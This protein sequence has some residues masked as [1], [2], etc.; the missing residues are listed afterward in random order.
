ML[1]AE[2]SYHLPGRLA[3]DGG[4]AR[5]DVRREREGDGFALL[6]IA[7]VEAVVHHVVVMNAVELD[8]VPDVHAVLVDQA[9][10]VRLFLSAD[11]VAEL[12]GERERAVRRRRIG[13]GQR[14]AGRRD[15]FR[16]VEGGRF[17]R[18]VEI[19]VAAILESLPYRR[20]DRHRFRLR[21]FAA[22]GEE[23]AD[24]V[25]SVRHAAL[26]DRGRHRPAQRAEGVPGQDIGERLEGDGAD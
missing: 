11:H 12:G 1:A 20:A 18:R 10:A 8:L 14:L 6:V 7:V 24:D 2:Q 13:R 17:H 9:V 16:R 3:L 26:Y 21:A 25:L 15:A 23:A 22:A 4:R 19:D 5:R